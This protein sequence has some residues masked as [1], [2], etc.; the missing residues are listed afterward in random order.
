[1]PHPN[2]ERRFFD[3][4]DFDLARP[5]LE[6]REE[7][8]PPVIAG[9]GAVF[10]DGSGRTEYELWKG[11]VERILPGAF[12]R[13]VVEDDVV[14]TFNHTAN[15]VLGRKSAGTLRLSVDSRGLAYEVDP[16]E[17]GSA[18][19]VLAL[20]RRGDVRGS[21]II[22]L[23]TDE[24]WRKEN[25]V[26]VR[27]VRGE[28]LIDV[29]PATVPA[30]EGTSAGVRAAGDAEQARESL[31]AWEAGQ[32]DKLAEAVAVRRRIIDLTQGGPGT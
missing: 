22:M 24:V 2:P 30:Y 11:A 17:T 15:L 4:D 27:E 31:E 9:Y 6:S 29:G 3:F 7:G 19:D 32:R 28:K 10:Y 18:R 23:V 1:M 26:R 21:S 12:D 5:R 16:P 14:A 13:A 8:K 25:S 20:L